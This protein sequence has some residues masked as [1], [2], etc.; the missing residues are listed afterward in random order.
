MLSIQLLRDHP[1]E[2]RASLARRH[3]DT[4]ID[5]ILRVE[6]N[7]RAAL[8]EAETLKARRN[9]VSRQLGRDRGDDAAFQQAREEM[10]QVGDEITIRDRMISALDERLNEMLLQLPNLPDPDVPDGEGEHDNLVVKTE[11]EPRGTAFKPLPHWDL[12]ERLG[13]IDFERGVKLSGSRFYVLKGAG[14]RLQRALTQ[15]MLDFHTAHEYTELYPPALVRSAIMQGAGQLPKFYEFLYRDAEEDLYLIPTAEVPITNLHR[16]EIIPPADLPMR[17]VACTPCFRREKVAAGRDV[18]G[19]KRVHQFEKV[20]MYQFVEPEQSDDVLLQML[21]NV[22]ELCRQLGVP[23]RVLQLCTGDLGFAA[24]K[25]YD[26]EVWAPGSEEWLEVSSVSNCREFQARRANIRYRPEAGARPQFPH[27]LNGSGLALPRS[28]IAV[29][30]N[31]QEPD[32][33]VIIPDVLR[34][35]MGGLDVIR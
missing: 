9:D 21:E 5:E 8:R 11:G 13:I 31:Y 19:I 35:Y 20:E 6:G 7:R 23:H 22:E 33:T 17:Y 24:A 29:L 12:A 2:V 34:P 18:R 15:W 4:P 14:A 10:R 30:E 28:I 1:E 27:T 32:G 3:T 16:D 26:I 25:T